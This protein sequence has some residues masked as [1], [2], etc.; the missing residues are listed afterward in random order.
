[1]L[2]LGSITMNSIPFKLPDVGLYEIEGYLYFE[3]DFLVFDVEKSLFG[4]FEADEQ[5]I[6]VEP[7]AIEEMEFK[8][9]VFKDKLC[10]RPKKHDLL[11]AMPGSFKEEL[12][13]SLSRKQR[14]KV[15][16]LIDEFNR[17]TL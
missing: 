13:L 15:Y 12:K 5:T 4:E 6:K 1:M 11:K 10:I 14:D 16:Q 9:G 8:K 17:R 7:S 2:N 3:E